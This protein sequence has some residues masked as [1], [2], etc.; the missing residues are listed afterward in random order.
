MDVVG[1]GRATSVGAAG[2][3][4]GLSPR[5]AAYYGAAATATLRLL[6]ATGAG[7]ALSQIGSVLATTGPGSFEERSVLA[8]ALRES[9]SIT[10]I[11]PDLIDKD[12]PS[13]EALMRRLATTGLSDATAA[14]RASTLMS[15]RKYVLE[16]Q[17]TLVLGGPAKIEPQRRARRRSA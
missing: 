16:R 13:R 9:E 11:A 8:R 2:A 7:L 4:I 15:W 1:S 10:S 17:A 12:G 3:A 6:V 5:H 14:R